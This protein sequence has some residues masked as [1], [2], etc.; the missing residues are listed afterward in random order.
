M[1]KW[2]RG[3]I[4]KRDKR[5]GERGG[6][7]WYNQEDRIRMNVKGG[8]KPKRWVKCTKY[9]YS[10]VWLKERKETEDGING[11]E[12]RSWE[13]I[14]RWKESKERGLRWMQVGKGFSERP[15]VY[16]GE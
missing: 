1:V 11:Y 15:I 8:H 9:M 5:K 3:K 10:T 6:K 4:S 16:T 12:E 13:R 14:N 7:G 2:I